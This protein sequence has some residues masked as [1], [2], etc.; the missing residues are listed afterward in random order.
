MLDA[1]VLQDRQYGSPETAILSTRSISPVADP[2]VRAGTGLVLSTPQARRPA[3][4]VISCGLSNWK[5]SVRNASL[6]LP[7]SFLPSVEAVLDLLNLRPGWNSHSAKRISPENALATIKVLGVLLDSATP[8][9]TVV[10]RVKGNIQ[11]EWHTE[12]IDIEVYIDSPSSVRFFAE[13]VTKAEVA[14]GVL[15][16]CEEEL[17]QWLMRVSSD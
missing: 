2:D 16:G 17:K 1:L 6:P 14:E 12:E 13:D 11:L 9:P 4:Q 8:P 7:A 10:P 5:V 3:R 15:T